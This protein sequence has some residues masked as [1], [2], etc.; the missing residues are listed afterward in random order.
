MEPAGVAVHAMS[1]TPF[2]LDGALDNQLFRAHLRFLGEVCAGVYVASQGSGEGDLL[3]LSE[4][5]ALYR[6]AADELYGRCEVV[7]AGIGLAMS[8]ESAVM[9]VT[10]A[11]TAGVDAVQ[12]LAPRPGPRPVRRDELETWFRTLIGAVS[13]DVHVSTNAV[14]SGYDVPLDV[15]EW[16]V[17]EFPQVRTVNVSSTD[18]AAVLALVARLAS[19]VSVRIGVTSQL[20]AASAA[21]ADGLLSFEANVAPAFVV[22]ACR[23]LSLDGLLALNAALARG[24]NPRSLKAG[25]EILGRDGGALRRP[26]LPLGPDDYAELERELRALGLVQRPKP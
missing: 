23:A 20:V 17:A 13:C 18:E 25:L 1:I 3:L 22:E 15:L 16:L 21:G 24:G 4:K 5:R 11:E 8:T 14:L 12:I 7:A 2:T 9:L 6:I 10:A 26:Y 19:R